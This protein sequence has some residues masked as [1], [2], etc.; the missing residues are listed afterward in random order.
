MFPTR[1]RVGGGGVSVSLEK[2]DDFVY[3]AIR[4]DGGG[5]DSLLRDFVKSAAVIRRNVSIP[6]HCD[7]AQE[8]RGLRV[9]SALGLGEPSPYTPC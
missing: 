6:V 4:L 8:R 3:N 1:K 2:M 5:D 7:H 9:L